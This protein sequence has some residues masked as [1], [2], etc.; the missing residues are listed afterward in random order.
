MKEIPVYCII[1]EGR[2]DF[3]DKDLGGGPNITD[4]R[5]PILP[6]YNIQAWYISGNISRTEIIKSTDQRLYNIIRII[7]PINIVILNK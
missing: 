5:T 7:G 2:N 3:K 4:A 1:K 6:G